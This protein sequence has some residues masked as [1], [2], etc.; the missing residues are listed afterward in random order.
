MMSLVPAMMPGMFKCLKEGDADFD[1][2][3]V[4]IINMIH[5]F[6]GCQIMGVTSW[7]MYQIVDPP[8]RSN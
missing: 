4:M 1:S 6:D 5:Q 7:F 2:N 8:I 3:V